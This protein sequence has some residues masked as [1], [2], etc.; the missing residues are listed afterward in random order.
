MTT[1]AHGN[2]LAEKLLSEISL[3]EQLAQANLKD[4]LPAG[5]EVS[6][7]SV[8]NHFALWGGEKT[9]GQLAKKFNVTKGAMTNTLRRL[10]QKDYVEIRPDRTDARSKKVKM[11]PAGK[12]A[13]AS[14]M[15][16][17]A[18]FYDSIIEGLGA[19]KVREILHSIGALREEID[20]E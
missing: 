4:A 15:A 9:P 20:A 7:F 2:D 12:Q 16:T 13:H 1:D 19:D 10:E 18:P 11:T 17:V 5:M 3:V 6:H 14:A 8:L